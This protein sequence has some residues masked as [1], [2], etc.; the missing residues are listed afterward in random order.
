MTNRQ[1][2]FNGTM[3]KWPLQKQTFRTTQNT[4]NNKT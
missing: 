1:V 2:K 4:K 3:T